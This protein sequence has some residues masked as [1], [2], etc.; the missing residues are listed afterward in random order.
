MAL[1]ATLSELSSKTLNIQCSILETL[2]MRRK[3]CFQGSPC[4]YVL[5][6]NLLCIA[7]CSLFHKT[8]AQP[9]SIKYI[10]QKGRKKSVKLNVVILSGSLWASICCNVWHFSCFALLEAFLCPW[11]LLTRK[12]IWINAFCF[13]VMQNLKLLVFL[14]RL[15]FMARCKY[16]TFYIS[17]RVRQVRLFF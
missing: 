1:G 15:F 9:T 7:F 10:P 14:C 2:E 12:K 16:K 4:F 5:R 17:P 6:S 8:A 11:N 3:K 13:A